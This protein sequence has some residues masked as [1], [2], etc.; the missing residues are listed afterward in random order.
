MLYIT[1]VADTPLITLAL[2]RVSVIAILC[3]VSQIQMGWITTTSATNARMQYAKWI[4]I[5]TPRQKPRQPMGEYKFGSLTAR[6]CAKQSVP[7]AGG[8]R[9]PDPTLVWSSFADVRPKY[10]G[11]PWRNLRKR[12]ALSGGHVLKSYVTVV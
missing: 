3:V 9:V 11:L 4:R 7:S 2:L 10:F 12:F 1:K 5:Y 6:N 8:I